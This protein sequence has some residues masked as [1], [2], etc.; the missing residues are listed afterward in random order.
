M[1][2]QQRPAILADYILFSR[3]RNCVP[4]LEDVLANSAVQCN[5]YPLGDLV[6]ETATKAAFEN[7]MATHEPVFEKFF[8][9]RLLGLEFSYPEDQCAITFEAKEFML[10][11]QGTLH[12][13]IIATVMDISMGH[14]L[15][16]VD[17]PAA[18]LE[19]KTQ[20]VK[21]AGVG[22]FTCTGTFIQ[23]GRGTSFLKSTLTNEQGKLVAFSTATWKLL[24][25][26]NP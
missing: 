13:G 18:T 11:P 25:P 15:K 19:M 6:N 21:P 8:L 14:L 5:D 9:A 10:N 7:A 3:F 2:A 17:G 22:R 4:G 20:Y 1:H 26:R 23:R 12:G 16:K 24:K